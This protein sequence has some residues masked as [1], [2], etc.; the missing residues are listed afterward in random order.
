[1]SPQA[2]FAALALTLASGAAGLGYE[3]VWQRYLGTLLGSQSEATAVV[4]ALFLAGLATGY[5]VFGR[6]CAREPRTHRLLVVYA[7]VPGSDVS[8]AGRNDRAAVFLSRMLRALSLAP[9][10]RGS[11]AL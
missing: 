7:A 4:L 1:M 10:V 8:R 3:V 5:A 6:L 11:C 9:T 2:R